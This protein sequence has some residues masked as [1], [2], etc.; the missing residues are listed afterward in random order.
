MRVRD[1]NAVYTSTSQA[2]GR[3][4]LGALLGSRPNG[5]QVKIHASI[6]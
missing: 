2:S 3:G 4:R 5:D 1:G 6:C